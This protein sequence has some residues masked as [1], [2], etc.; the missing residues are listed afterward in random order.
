[1]VRD[2]LHVTLVF[3]GNF[4]EKDIVSL[5]EAAGII[6]CPHIKLSFEWIDFW[7]R[8]KIMCLHA[9][10]VPDDLVDLVKSL[11]SEA[12]AF[13]YE[14][15]KRPYKPHMTIARKAGFFQPILLAQP[16]VLRWAVFELIESI[17]TPKGV[18]YRPLK[19]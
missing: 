10:T 5:Q 16:L 17:S 11:E 8:Q 14:P 12:S 3:I 15:E 1:M 13:G 4:P 2:N 6:Q 9:P 19:Q 18:R 7:K